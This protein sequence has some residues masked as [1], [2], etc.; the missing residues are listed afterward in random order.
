MDLILEMKDEI[1]KSIKDLNTRI[2]SIKES[3]AIFAE[4]IEDFYINP[5]G[6]LSNYNA[7][8]Y[9]CTER[10]YPIQKDMVISGAYEG[11][12][13]AKALFFY[14]KNKTPI[15]EYEA[16]QY[17]SYIEVTL[18][19]DILPENAAYVRMT[20][21]DA[22]VVILP[23]FLVSYL[24]VLNSSGSSEGT[25][26]VNDY[27]GPAIHTILAGSS[28]LWGNGTMVDKENSGC[29][30][31]LECL[32]FNISRGIRY[33]EVDVTGDNVI[34]N[35]DK[36]MFGAGIK[37][38]GIDS[39]LSFDFEGDEINICQAILR[40][41]NYADVLVAAD[42]EQILSFNNKNDTYKDNDEDNF[43]ADGE[44]ASFKLSHPYTYYHTL[45][46]DGE[47]VPVKLHMSGQEYDFGTEGNY[48][49]VI[50][51]AY[52]GVR[53]KVVHELRF[54]QQLLPANG[55]NIKITY[56][57]GKLICIED[58]T[59]GQSDNDDSVNEWNY[60]VGG[61]P[62]DLLNPGTIFS[63]MEYRSIDKRAFVSYKFK[64]K[65]KRRISIKITGGINP[66]FIFNFATT[67]LHIISNCAIGGY[68]LKRYLTSPF[69]N[70]DYKH[71]FKFGEPHILMIQPGLGDD[72]HYKERVLHRTVNGNSEQT[73]KSVCTRGEVDR[74]TYV[75][76][77][78]YTIRYCTGIIT[79]ID[80]TSLTCEE[81]KDSETKIGDIVRIGN[82]TGDIRSICVR[83]I[84][85]VN[86]E[87]GKIEWDEPI[88]VD[89]MLCVDSLQDLVGAE[90]N[91]RDL[92]GFESDLRTFVSNVRKIKKDIHI[93][94]VESE[95]SNYWYRQSWGYQIIIRKV[96]SDTP[97][98]SIINTEKWITEFANSF[99]SGK[100]YVDIVPDGSSIYTVKK[101]LMT[102]GF[103]V[104]VNGIDVYG[105]DCYVT[106]G[107]I[108]AVDSSLHGEEISITEAYQ[109][110]GE[111]IDWKIVFIRNAPKNSDT[112][113][114]IYA[115][116]TWSYDL[117][118]PDI[119]GAKLYGELMGCKIIE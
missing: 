67:R 109:G 70:M 112:L 40:T 93:V 76:E 6:V 92:S 12:G 117:C 41:S 18:N 52:D 88:W 97:N 23:K 99:I 78:N 85:A 61:T 2:D 87:E 4:T 81:I 100:N 79:S 116:D 113:R 90:I 83:E 108:W 62:Y 54:P 96:M 119:Y 35:N 75:S 58:S 8:I 103:K 56:K 7:A 32:Y 107:Y 71:L 59:V 20:G 39:S 105:K 72:G 48:N 98:S 34:F 25:V 77:D 27:N 69:F 86:I 13:L 64:D 46:V 24:E 33:D 82:Y 9:K 95:P 115:D 45:T 106:P 28:I 38:Q 51:R 73:A 118:H 80:T 5:D 31:L 91:I 111:Y 63:G 74:I 84:T 14:D 102:Q 47:L 11:G 68:S 50:V 37:I 55:Q 29:G 49:A 16:P 66:Y 21:K 1:D 94:F 22:P 19:D 89:N 26:M 114:L 104:L 110:K 65:K 44:T 15:S 3:D 10:Y 57:V 53:N 36:L 101:V 60:G 43:I 42:G 17:N 30:N